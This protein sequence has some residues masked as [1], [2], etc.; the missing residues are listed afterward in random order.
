M[1][2]LVELNDRLGYFLTE[3]FRSHDYCK[4]CNSGDKKDMSFLIP[5]HCSVLPLEDWMT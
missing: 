2:V 4:I 1:C 3:C 5:C